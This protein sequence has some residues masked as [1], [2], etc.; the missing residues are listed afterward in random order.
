MEAR[1]ERKAKLEEKMLGR[2]RDGTATPA[3]EAAWRRWM[4]IT[5]GSSS[6]EEEEV[7]TSQI[8]FPRLS[9]SL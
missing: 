4:G 6:W 1:E 2:V 7:E 8:L 3:E 5:P 9:T